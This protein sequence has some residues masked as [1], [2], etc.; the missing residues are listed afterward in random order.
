[1]EDLLDKNVK[2]IKELINGIG[3][4]SKLTLE[5]KNFFLYDES[6]YIN[7]TF[8]TELN[9]K[10]QVY[11]LISTHG[12]GIKSSEL[13]TPQT[14]LKFNVLEDKYKEKIVLTLE[15][16]RRKQKLNVKDKKITNFAILASSKKNKIGI[17]RKMS[18]AIIDEVKIDGIQSYDRTR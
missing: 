12:I 18:Y 8:Y 15:D 1:M 2:E 11:G 13:V 3:D 7:H 17:K 9:K 16:I 10:I 4:L 14:S 5:Q 6:N